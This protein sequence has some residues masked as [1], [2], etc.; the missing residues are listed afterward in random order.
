[1]GNDPVVLGTTTRGLERAVPVT[2][3]QSDRRRHVHIVG[4]SGT[5]KSSLLLGM[6]LA[7]LEA[8]RGFT[9][10]DPHGDLVAALADAV[11]P[12]RIES[13]IYFDPADLTA[14]VG[15][16]PISRVAPDARPLA[17]AHLVSAFELIWQLSMERTPRLLRILN[18]AIR[19]LL[20]TPSSTLL[21]MP[22]LLIDES[23]RAPF[24]ARC[25][26]PVVRAFWTDEFVRYRAQFATEAIDPV[27]TRLG[28]LLSDP[29]VRHVLG[30]P[31]STLDLS[32]IMDGRW[33]LLVNLSK[34]RLG[35][36][37]SH[38]IGSI[39][40][41][42]LV[43]AAESRAALSEHQRVDHTLAVD[44]FQNFVGGS[45][46]HAYS[47]SRKWRL[48]LCTV[49]Q[50]L[51]Q[52]PEHI[53]TAV[54]GNASTLVAFRVGADDAGLLA[55]ELGIDNSR[56][57]IDTPNFSAWCRLLRDG[58]VTEPILIDTV[59]SSPTFRGSFSRMR[60]RTYARHARPRA[61]VEAMIERQLSAS[62][63]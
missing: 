9:L 3:S 18:A 34:G 17:A 24:I 38:L 44:E 14:S 8:G 57:L 31:R 56:A 13:T 49:H 45:F 25:I 47:E 37:P 26:D 23:F 63:T 61:V 28:L 39:L 54:F 36:G 7:D 58:M 40:T 51:S 35:E 52:L 62:V 60:A 10:L 48:A 4:K 43:Q 5:G 50:H 22:R 19:L 41:T 32:R 42:M 27:Q 2:L 33:A 20:D 16:N 30:Q 59:L 29:A 15:L 46:A 6:L 11:P 21:L 1:M 53:R 12:H 55:R